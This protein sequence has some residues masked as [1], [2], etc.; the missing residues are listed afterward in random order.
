MGTLAK[1][2]W[3]PRRTIIYAAWDGEEEGL[4]G[5]TEWVE[6]HADELGRKA[7]AYINTDGIRPRLPR[8][9]RIGT[10]SSAW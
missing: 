8:R 7:V 4:L 6:S 2:G 1:S 3:R 9:R 5:S 10:A